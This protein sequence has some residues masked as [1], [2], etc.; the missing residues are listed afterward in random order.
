MPV[1]ARARPGLD[2]ADLPP[3]DELGAQMHALLAELFPIHRSITGEGLRRTAAVLSR[4]L[5]LEVVETPS[6]TQLFDWVVPREWNLREAW[7]AAPDGRRVADTARSSL[8]V[9]AYSVPTR[10]RLRLDAL[11]PHLFSLPD[12]P[13]LIPFRTS[14]H[15]DNWG[16]CLEHRVLESLPEG[17]YEAV[18]DATLEPGSMTSAELTIPGASDREILLT[19]YWCHPS[20]ANDNLSGVVLLATLA[21]L[22]LGRPLHYTYRFLWSPGTLGPLA[23][24]ERNRD[25]LDRVD[26]GIVAACVGDAGPLTYKRSRQ[27]T[28]RLDRAVE[29]ALSDGGHPHSV[30]DFVP[31]GG[32]ERQFCSPGFDLPVGCLMRTPNMEYPEYHT[33]ADDLELVRP[34]QLAGSLRAYLDAIDVLETDVVYR[35]TSP[36][37]EPQ[38]GKRGLYRAIS[39]GAPRPEE[40]GARAIQWVLNLADGRHSLLDMAD[41]SGVPF[42]ALREAAWKLADAG[43]LV[44]EEAA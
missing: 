18:V 28:S 36:H 11:R 16:F 14:Y 34:A 38:L 43:L 23:W 35:S 33:S 29:R 20:L 24:L 15:D 40:V 10:E 13:D 19:G 7:L 26:G 39:A 12:Q 1:D 2:L 5:P 21:R 27:G 6:G 31:W 44:E 22:L 30:R 41:R 42:A 37:G 17:E 4:D 25:R 9:L 32:D 8:H 3:A